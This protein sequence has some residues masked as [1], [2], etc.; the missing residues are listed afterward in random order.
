M[1]QS[2]DDDDDDDHTSIHK[3]IIQEYSEEKEVKKMKSY[4]MNEQK[5]KKE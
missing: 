3:A 2:F 4:E 1:Y 5:R